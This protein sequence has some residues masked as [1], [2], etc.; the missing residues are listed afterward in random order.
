MIRAPR[1]AVCERRELHG[2]EVLKDNSEVL[3]EYCR[4]CRDKQIYNKRGGIYDTAKHTRAHFRD[5]VQPFGRT[6]AWFKKLYG[7]NVVKKAV[8]MQPQKKTKEQIEK[9]WDEAQKDAKRDLR[10]RDD[11]GKKMI[12]T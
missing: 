12:F 2:Y 11:Y 5:T 1:E 10:Q 8:K 6:A 3:I 4:Y 7:W 9:D